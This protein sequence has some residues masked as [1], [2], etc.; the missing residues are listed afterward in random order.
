[1]LEVGDELDAALAADVIEDHSLIALGGPQK[2]VRIYETEDAA[3]PLHEIRK[4]TEWIYAIE[5]SPDG[6][7]LATAD[8]NGGLFVWET[9]TAREYLDLRGHGG[10]VTSVSWRLDS[11]VL[12]S[13]GEDGSVRLW[14]MEKGGQIKS[15]TAHGGG[16]LS[17]RFAKDGRL[18]TAGRDRTVKIWDGEGNQLQAF[19]PHGDLALEAVL[20]HDGSR[21]IGGDWNG[22]IRMWN[23]A[24]AT[25]LATLAMNPSTLEMAAHAAALEALRA[26]EK[27]ELAEAEFEAN[28]QAFRGLVA[29][30]TE[31][32]NQI[33]AAQSDL[34]KSTA[35][36]NAAQGAS[37]EKANAL[38]KAQEALAAAQAAF[39]A[40]QSA[41]SAAQSDAEAKAAAVQSIAARVANHQAAAE[42]LSTEKTAAEQ[43]LAEKKA[44]LDAASQEAAA[45]YQKAGKAA[46]EKAAYEE[47]QSAQPKSS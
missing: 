6:V 3:K 39:D 24:D 12:A 15:W 41:L 27:L 22:E 34:E 1:M 19:E 18:I 23:V 7:L 44:A 11:N 46:A 42:K 26:Q 4:H 38:E 20:T 14:E 17:V 9:E 21:A 10:A 36:S 47:S 5:F 40:A 31:S 43:S 33:A 2:V 35:E 13:A 30:I 16:T 25:L 32:A 29:S 45:A 37:A 28:N 8:R